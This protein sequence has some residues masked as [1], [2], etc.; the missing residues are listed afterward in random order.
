MAKQ[1][2]VLIA[3]GWYDYRLHKGIAAYAQE[4]GWHLSESLAHERVLPWGWEG[5]GVL[6]WLGAGD[7]LVEFVQSLK[8]PTVDFSMRRPHLPFARVLQD[9][10]HASSLVARHF[11]SLGFR[12]FI[13]YSENDNWSYEE[14]GRGFAAALKKVGHSCQWIR[15]QDSKKPAQGRGEWSRRRLWLAGQL[16]ALP[17][18]AAI[19]AANDLMAVEV[20]EVCEQAGLLVPEQIAIVGAENYLLAV[21]SMRTPI[22]S[23]DTNL[24]EQGYQGA[25]LLARLM[26]G[27]PRPR[28]HVR[29]AA[30]RVIVRKSSDTLAVAHPNLAR[31]LR[32]ISEHFHQPMGVGEVANAAAMSRRA[33][34]QAFSENLGKTPGEQITFVRLEHAKRLLAESQEKMESIAEASGYQS[35]T[36]LFIAFKKSTGV[37]PTAFRKSV[38]HGKPQNEGHAGKCV[39]KLRANLTDS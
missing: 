18:P 34:H 1:K 12:N 2:N 25:I 22:S 7:D 11:L 17:Y 33:L 39:P 21:D 9:H 13:F 23:V 16:S 24:E 35:A 37:S 38:Q 29:I 19:F 31:A 15:W 30:A 6:A 27:E 8:K 28:T 26:Q 3:P 14:R 5:D 36:S 20:L 32:F 10:A 4:H